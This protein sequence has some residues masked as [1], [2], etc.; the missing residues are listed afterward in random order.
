MDAG[1]A[2]RLLRVRNFDSAVL[3]PAIIGWEGGDITEYIMALGQC[4]FMTVTGGCELHGTGMKPLECRVAP[5][6]GTGAN[7]SNKKADAIAL[8]IE[9]AWDTRAGIAAMVR[10]RAL[11]E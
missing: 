5:C 1:H 11:N 6:G 2:D 10:W 8:A 4:T 7:L 3:R 9:R